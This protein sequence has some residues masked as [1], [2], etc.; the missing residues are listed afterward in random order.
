MRKATR[1]RAALQRRCRNA[2]ISRILNKEWGMIWSPVEEY[3]LTMDGV[4]YRVRQRSSQQ[5]KLFRNEA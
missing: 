5:N 1:K 3:L 2:R 4:T